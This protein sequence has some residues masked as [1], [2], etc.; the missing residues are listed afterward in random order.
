MINHAINRHQPSFDARNWFLML[1]IGHK[2]KVLSNKLIDGSGYRWAIAKRKDS[3]VS[4][5]EFGI[6]VSQLTL[7]KKMI[8]Q[9]FYC[10]GS[11]SKRIVINRRHG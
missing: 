2:K 8:D 1:L 7:S 3:P 4:Q 11:F 5:K 6:I 10:W 9:F